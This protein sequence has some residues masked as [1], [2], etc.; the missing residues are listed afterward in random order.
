MEMYKVLEKFYY[1][2]KVKVIGVCNFEIEYLEC[3]LNEC[4]VILVLN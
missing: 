2:G 1:D 4:D 3:L